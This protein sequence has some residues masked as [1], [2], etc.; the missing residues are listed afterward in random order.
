MSK[1]TLGQSG[2]Q[3]SPIAFGGNVF[4]WTLD[5]AQS[6]AMLDA[7]VDN[8]LDF[9]DTADMYSAWA[10]GHQGGESESIIGKWLKRSGKRERIVLATKVGMEMGHG[11]KGLKAD[12]IQ[13][14][15]EDS[16][17]RLQTDYIDLYQAHQDDT[18]TPL[19]ETLGAFS[20]LIAQ[21]KVRVI[22]ASNYSA[23]RLR[24]AHQV[25]QRLGVPSYQSLQPHYNLHARKT[26]EE[27]LEPVVQ[28]LGIGV[29]SYFSLASG[30]LTGKYRTR[31]DIT[32]ARA[33]M[34]KGYMD[35]RGVT[36]LSALD[37]VA[38]ARDATPAQVALAWLIARP[39]ITAPIASATSSKQLADLVASTRLQLSE[40]EVTMLNQASAY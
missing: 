32:G 33:E 8:G 21:G 7:I 39:S 4:G 11:G 27:E 26:Y 38:A 28:E 29:I 36:I 17:K 19:E 31:E 3:V 10:P 35:E 24:E 9:I 40:D 18:D 14:A 23:E 34:V 22:G 16:L 2:L 6:F 20:R 1:R 12:Y 25:A 13:K 15:V 37:E 5:E 30:F